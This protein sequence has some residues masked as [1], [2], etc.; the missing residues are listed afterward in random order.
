M[1]RFRAQL[2]GRPISP[3]RARRELAVVD[4]L[5]TG[6]ASRDQDGVIYYNVGAEIEEDEG[7]APM[8]PDQERWAEALAVD[9]KHGARSSEFVAARIKAL[10]DAGDTAGTRRWR[11]IK[12][13]LARLVKE[14]Q[15]PN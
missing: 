13:R 2:F 14:S 5:E 1:P 10:S 11:E 4:L 8:T 9:R 6:E 3:W 15:R 7:D 12:A